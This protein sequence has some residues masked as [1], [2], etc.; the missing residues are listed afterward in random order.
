VPDFLIVILAFWVL[1][2]P[3]K[4]HL[5][6]AFLLG[7]LMDIQTSQFLGIHSITYLITAFLMLFW[8]RRLL[9]TTLLG[10]YFIILQV[11]LISHTAQI[12]ILWLLNASNDVSFSYIIL[13][14]FIEA[15][16]WP[17]IS[18]FLIG[19]TSN[20]SRNHSSLN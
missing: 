2:T 13:P 3:D 11:L 10:Q 20:F 9:N 12:L 17:M 6:A 5:L 19:Q 18:K 15:L 4:I 16:L 14:S 7:V 8:S 1:H